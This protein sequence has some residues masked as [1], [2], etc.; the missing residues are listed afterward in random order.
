MEH[1]FTFKRGTFN[2]V[3]IFVSKAWAN[4]DPYHHPEPDYYK[5][6]VLKEHL[7]SQPAMD[8]FDTYYTVLN[9]NYP[10]PVFAFVFDSAWQ[11]FLRGCTISGFEFY[12]AFLMYRVLS[13]YAYV[14]HL[15]AKDPDDMLKSFGDVEA[16]FCTS[17][18]QTV[19][20]ENLT[21]FR[22]IVETR[23]RIIDNG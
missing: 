8:I 11:G 19:I 4:F 2:N 1:F 6:L 12:E 3:F 7:P 21:E 23:R 22:K 18:A 13:E 20:G 10:K 14:V 16:A 15:T 9:E 17:E 5:T